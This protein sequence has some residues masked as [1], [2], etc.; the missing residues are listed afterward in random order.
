MKIIKK[1][2]K[3][4]FL[5]FEGK[6]ISEEYLIGIWDNDKCLVKSNSRN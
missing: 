2:K 6:L 4:R 5:T 3:G 1:D